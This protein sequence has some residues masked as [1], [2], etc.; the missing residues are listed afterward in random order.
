M[1]RLLDFMRAV[2]EALGRAEHDWNNRYV[3]ERSNEEIDRLP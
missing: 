2:C 3:G 1:K